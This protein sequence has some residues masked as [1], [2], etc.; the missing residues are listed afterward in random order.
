MKRYKKEYLQPHCKGKILFKNF[1]V[2]E[3]FI[4]RTKSN[5]AL[6]RQ[7]TTAEQVQLT[8]DH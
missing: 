3:E 6:F 2:Q 7:N 4:E 8:A 1:T 5:I